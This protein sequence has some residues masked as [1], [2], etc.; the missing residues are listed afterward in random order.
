MYAWKESFSLRE[1]EVLGLIADGLTNREISQKLYLSTETVKWYNKQI[2]PKLGV[3]N[4]TQAVK[5]AVELELLIPDKTSQVAVKPRL[6]SNLP[7]QLTSYIGRKV[8]I[9]EIKE[10]LMEHRLVVL[11]GPGGTGKTRLALQVAGELPGNY[12]DGVWLVELASINNPAQVLNAIAN[13]LSLSESNK[14]SLVSV[15]KHYL[16]NKHLLLLIDN[17]EHLLDAAS[18]VGDLLAGAPGV[19]ILATSRERLHL[20]GEQEYPVHPLGLP[21]IQRPEP[22]EQLLNYDAIK[23]FI[24]RARAAKPGFIL[25]ED[26]I[27]AVVR[28]CKLLDGLPLA[29]ELSAPLVKVF[30]PSVIAER[31]EASL[32]ALPGG[33]R[34]APARQRT[35]RATLDWSYNLLQEDE[36]DL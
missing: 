25:G 32:D 20:Y 24:D 23:L 28:I 18:L 16:R 17:F 35:L 7:A 29:I 4:R 10:L 6:L 15:L 31:L 36:K 8:E 12:R 13:V 26:Q 19:T 2:F 11:T 30:M 27:P 3:S 21:D 5:K 22:T 9:A 34:D 33:P 1:I 14:M